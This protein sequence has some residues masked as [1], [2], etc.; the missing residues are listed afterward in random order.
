VNSLINSPSLRANFGSGSLYINGTSGSSAWLV[1]SNTSVAEL[2]DIGGTDVNGLPGWDTSISGSSALGM[3][4][5]A[6]VK[7]FS[8]T[9]DMS[10][11]EDLSI[12]YATARYGASAASSHL[13]EYSTDGTNWLTVGTVTGPTTLNTYATVSL[14]SFDELD[15]VSTAYLRMTFLGASGSTG[16]TRLDNIQMNATAVPEPGTFALFAVGLACLLV[17]RSSQRKELAEK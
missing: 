12:S 4:S 17:W 14:S 7:S 5:R 8:F 15:A 13:W 10:G 3:Y 6:R 2:K 9:L 1:S 16:V 11:Y